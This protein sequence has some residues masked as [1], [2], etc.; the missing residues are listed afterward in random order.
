MRAAASI[1]VVLS[2]LTL[3]VGLGRRA[4]TDSDEA[5]Y[6][7]AGREMVERG[8]WL[9]PHFNYAVRF[10]KPILFY[11]VVATAY[12][13]AGVGPAAARFGSALAG[14]GIVLLAFACGRIDHRTVAAGDRSGRDL[15]DRHRSHDPPV[16]GHVT[17]YVGR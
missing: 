7:E 15:G 9:T 17:T 10:Q 12:S 13:I 11:W 6:A 8:D 2:A 4:I 1:L 3:F 5:F 14:L 16:A